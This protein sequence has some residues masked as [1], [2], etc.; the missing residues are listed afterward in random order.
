MPELKE[1]VIVRPF[2]PTSELKGTIP[3]NVAKWLKKKKLVKDSDFV[4]PKGSSK[5][6]QEP[7]KT[8]AEKQAEAAAKAAEEA[9]KKAK[10]E[11]E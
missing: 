10:K 9:A 3:S 1:G 8:E 4:K 2:G 6:P 5:P 7:E 11:E